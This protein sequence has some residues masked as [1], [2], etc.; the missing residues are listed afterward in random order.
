MKKR[1]LN[2]R[3]PRYKKD[4][5]KPQWKRRVLMKKDNHFKMYFLWEK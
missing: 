3:N 1:K 5:D 2:S 4:N